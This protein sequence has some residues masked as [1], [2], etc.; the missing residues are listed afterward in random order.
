MDQTYGIL[1]SEA[2]IFCKE[3]YQS[4][5]DSLS[6]LKVI[7]E[8]S[9]HNPMQGLQAIM[10]LKH[11]LDIL[12]LNKVWIKELALFHKK[13]SKDYPE[14]LLYLKDDFHEQWQNLSDW[15]ESATHRD[16]LIKEQQQW[17]PHQP[18]QQIELWMQ[19][20]TE[21][22]KQYI[23]HYEKCH[24]LDCQHQFTH[25]QLA[26]YETLIQQGYPHSLSIQ[27]PCSRDQSLELMH[28]PF[29]RCGYIP[30]DQGQNS[31]SS[32]TITEFLSTSKQDIVSSALISAIETEDYKTAV[33]I[34]TQKNNSESIPLS[35]ISIKSFEKR[36]HGKTFS[37]E[38]LRQEFEI[39]LNELPPS[40]FK[41]DDH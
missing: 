7:T 19:S 31:W 27:P 2:W 16:S 41:I 35:K 13:H 25:D 29:C 39:W 30:Q 20:A 32:E 38:Q 40:A 6:K 24:K 14:L 26:L 1:E 4:I 37:R 5:Q 33:E 3:Q 21:W 9:L 36:V 22:K 10:D 8:E 28:K 15:T 23:F 12:H 17:L 11:E 18:W 34:L